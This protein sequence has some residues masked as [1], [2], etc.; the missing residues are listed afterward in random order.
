MGTFRSGSP[1][2]DRVREREEALENYPRWCCCRRLQSTKELR[3]SQP[4]LPPPPPPRDH[5]SVADKRR[6]RLSDAVDP[7][8]PAVGS[9]RM[10]RWIGIAAR[11]S[12]SGLFSRSRS[13]VLFGARPLSIEGRHRRRS[14][15]SLSLFLFLC[16]HSHLSSLSSLTQSTAS[17]SHR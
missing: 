1:S 5:S 10:T 4:P 9:C 15:L 8:L 13:G 14:R 17:D 16:L 2:R 7:H 12:K 11:R 6:L 3:R